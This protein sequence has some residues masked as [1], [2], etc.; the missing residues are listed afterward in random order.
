M[1]E[2]RPNVLPFAPVAPS[3]AIDPDLKSACA[4][5]R[6]LRRELYRSQLEASI[7]L[8]LGRAT[9]E[10]IERCESDPRGSVMAR[11]RRMVA[12]RKDRAA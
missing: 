9:V 3:A 11:M 2:T 5:F 4:E 1:S 7:G 12:E 10:R 6:S 8:G